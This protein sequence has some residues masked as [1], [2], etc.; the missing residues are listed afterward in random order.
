M[1]V[2]LF[3]FFSSLRSEGQEDFSVTVLTS[4]RGNP[5]TRQL[6]R[7]GQK[8]RDEERLYLPVIEITLPD[9][10]VGHGEW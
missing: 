1:K 6:E 3:L 2:Q 10:E 5:S 8:E 7:V 4:L 9:D